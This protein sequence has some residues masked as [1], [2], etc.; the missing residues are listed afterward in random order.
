MGSSHI[1]CGVN[2]PYV[3]QQ[4]S[5]ELGREAEVFTLGWPWAGFDA[6]YF[7]A[8]DLLAQRKVQMIVI[9]DE[10][11]SPIVPHPQASR[12]FRIGNDSKSLEGLDAS[13]KC[14]LYGSAVLGTPRTLLS[15][16]RPNLIESLTER[17]PDFWEMQFQAPNFAEQLGAF[18]A[19]LAFNNKRGDFMV[20]VPPTVAS[21]DDAV[22][23]SAE[24]REA[25]RFSERPTRPYQLHFAR[26]LA[27]LC[28]ESGTRLVFLDLPVFQE[29]EQEK[30]FERVAWP[31]LLTEP[32]SL[33]GIPGG[34]LFEGIS[35]ED[36]PRFFYNKSHLNQNG[37]DR[38]TPLITPALFKL[39]ASTN[40]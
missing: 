16:I 13:F 4:L 5:K 19:Q 18:R 8:K 34:K 31:E 24:T 2:T 33:V 37:Q 11:R 35:E 14:S 7:I 3:Q 38:F 40:F 39:Y 21:P 9:Y 1:W 30:V 10:D 20:F 36:V 17:D 28:R 29:R 12:W 25:F 6:L 22:I 15:F 32:V 27:E 26:K 23:F